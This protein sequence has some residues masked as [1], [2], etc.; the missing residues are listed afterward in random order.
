[1]HHHVPIYIYIVIFKLAS[2]DVAKFNPSSYSVKKQ[3]DPL[4]TTLYKQSCEKK[5]LSFWN[6]C[7][8]YYSY[9]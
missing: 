2:N 3:M 9:V 4:A 7:A 8:K 5:H 6:V 1:M